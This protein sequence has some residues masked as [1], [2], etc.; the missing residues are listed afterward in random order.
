M[1]R[2]TLFC[3]VY[4]LFRFLA[5]L[6]P[7]LA[8]YGLD[9]GRC[10]AR[11][12]RFL[13]PIVSFF[14]NFC[15]LKFS[16]KL[17][18]CSNIRSKRGGGNAAFLGHLRANFNSYNPFLN[19]LNYLTSLLL[20]FP[21]DLINKGIHWENHQQVRSHHTEVNSTVMNVK[22][23]GSFGRPTCGHVGHHVFQVLDGLVGSR[24]ALRIFQ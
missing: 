3:W 5:L 8:Q 14:I 20:R 1:A 9:F 10:G 12:W 7:L 4:V 18:L 16:R 17:A 24:E 11:F 15:E 19:R 23:D 21:Q 13:V 2:H 6:S 22:C